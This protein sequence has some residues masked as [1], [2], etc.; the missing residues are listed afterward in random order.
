MTG[1]PAICAACRCLTGGCGSL[2]RGRARARL[3]ALCEAEGASVDHAGGVED[4]D[5]QRAAAEEQAVGQAVGG[6]ALLELRQQPGHCEEHQ[7]LH[8]HGDAAPYQH[9]EQA[10]AVGDAAGQRQDEAEQRAEQGDGG[11]RVAGADQWQLGIGRQAQIQAGEQ[12]EQ[13]QG[14]DEV[15][16]EVRQGFQQVHGGIL[17]EVG[18]LARRRSGAVA[19]EVRHEAAAVAGDRSVILADAQ[20][21]GAVTDHP[22]TQHRIAAGEVRQRRIGLPDARRLRVRAVA[23]EGRIGGE[24]A[25]VLAL[26]RVQ[27]L[28]HLGQR[29]V[30]AKAG[31]Q[32]VGMRGE[33]LP[34]DRQQRLAR[35]QQ[36]PRRF[37]EVDVA[38]RDM[39]AEL[40]LQQPLPGVE[41][42]AVADRPAAFVDEGAPRGV[43]ADPLDR[44]VVGGHAGLV[45]GVQQV[46][47]V[48]GV[49]LMAGEGGEVHRRAGI[50]L[51]PAVDQLLVQGVELVGCR[52][53]V[54][55]PEP[56]HHAGLQQAG[57]GVGVYAI[58]PI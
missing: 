47:G 8:Q 13:R 2:S 15:G 48:A 35:Q 16:E 5:A 26:A 49:L 12:A 51:A 21:G 36:L 11:G 33:Q 34:E 38:C 28:A 50:E 52:Q 24:D 25:D 22:A 1:D 3:P 39:G 45:G 53:H 20:A 30:V 6:D 7:R 56:L 55:Q 27:R 10:G 44:Q 31:R 4:A 29:Q 43:E 41:L 23:G 19:E 58:L 18:L 37:E 57:R 42:E 14:G 9:V 17:L 46:Q 54:L 40:V 32:Q